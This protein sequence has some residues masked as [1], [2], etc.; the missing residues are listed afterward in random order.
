[1]FP[2]VERD[3]KFSKGRNGALQPEQSQSNSHG[4]VKSLTWHLSW[5]PAALV[6]VPCVEPRVGLFQAKQLVVGPN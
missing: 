4:D 5:T 3:S 6:R 1:M 2:V